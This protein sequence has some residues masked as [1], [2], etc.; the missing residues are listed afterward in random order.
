MSPEATHATLGISVGANQGLSSIA[1]RPQSGG[2]ESEDDEDELAGGWKTAKPDQNAMIKAD[3]S[4]QVLHSGSLWKKG[5]RRKVCWLLAFL[6]PQYHT[7]HLL[8]QSIDMEEAVVCPA[9]CSSGIL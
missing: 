9:P 6:S 2:E 8:W 3:Q 7:R 1:E 5:N 4:L